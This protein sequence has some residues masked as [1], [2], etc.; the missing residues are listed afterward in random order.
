MLDVNY[1]GST[2]FGRAYRERLDGEWGIA[3]VA[4]CAAGARHLAKAG[5]ADAHAHRHRRAAAPAAT[6]P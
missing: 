1:S 6:R 3:D 5:L 2:G 4:D